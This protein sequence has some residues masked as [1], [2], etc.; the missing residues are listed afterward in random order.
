MFF[1]SSLAV[2][3]QHIFFLDGSDVGVYL[4]EQELWMYSKGRL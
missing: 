2:S 4:S 3:G 1:I